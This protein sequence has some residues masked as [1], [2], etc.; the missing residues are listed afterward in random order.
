M[1]LPDAILMTEMENSDYVGEANF[2]KKNS[3]IMMYLCYYRAYLQ[4]HNYFATSLRIPWKRFNNMLVLKF[5][6]TN[7]KCNASLSSL[8]LVY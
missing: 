4:K 1:A 7:I 6:H 2:A 5:C 3:M 8:W